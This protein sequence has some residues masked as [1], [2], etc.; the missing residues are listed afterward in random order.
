MHTIS[1]TLNCL[2]GSPPMSSK[3]YFE[4]FRTTHNTR[5]SGK[6]LMPPEVRTETVSL[7]K[8]FYF[9]GSKLFNN[10]PNKMKD[11]NSV[12]IFKTRI[13]EFYRSQAFKLLLKLVAV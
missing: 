6:N 12:M 3:D 2:K 8:S 5:G 11:L 7:G 4:A 13:L 1:L 9:N 10:I